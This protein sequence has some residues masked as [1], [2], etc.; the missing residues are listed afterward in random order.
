MPKA[1][2]VANPPF[3]FEPELRT[4]RAIPRGAAAAKGEIWQFDL[5]R[6]DGDTTNFQ[7]GDD[8][9]CFA[10]L[11]ASSAAGVESGVFAIALEAI[12]EDKP[13]RWALCGLV[14]ALVQKNSGNIAINDVLVSTASQKYL[15]A[16]VTA[17][18]R[19]LAKAM[20]AK[21]GPSTATLAWV[22]FDGLDG[23]GV[24]VS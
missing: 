3:G 21:T 11:V 5:A 17:G 12:A 8:N 7:V 20:E 1:S 23:F 15:D 13:G 9:S 19:H 16:D 4:V 24:H 6:S 10:N 2:S 22:W 14:E 18:A